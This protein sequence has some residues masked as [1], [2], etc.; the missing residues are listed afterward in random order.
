MDHPVIEKFSEIIPDGFILGQYDTKVKNKWYQV[1]NP[2]WPYVIH[3]EFVFS[4]FTTSLE[5]HLE[6]DKVK[7]IYNLLIFFQSNL[8]EDNDLLK[9]KPFTIDPTWQKGRGR[10]CLAVSNQEKPEVIASLMKAFIESTVDDI[11]YELDKLSLLKKETNNELFS[12]RDYWILNLSSESKSLEFIEENKVR[13]CITDE[14]CSIK[15]GHNVILWGLSPEGCYGLGS[16]YTDI[17]P[18]N[19]KTTKNV[20]IQLDYNFFSNP[21]LKGDIS[22]NNIFNNIIN[23]NKNYFKATDNQCQVIMAFLKNL[24]YI[25]P[26]KDILKSFNYKQTNFILN[27]ILYGP[28]GTGKTYNTIDL[29]A[30]IIGFDTNNHQENQKIFKQLLG[31]QIEFITFHQNY[32]YEDFIQGLKPNTENNGNGNLSFELKDGIFKRIA[33]RALDNYKASIINRNQVKAF[34][35]FKKVF[36]ELVKPL[37]EDGEPI[38]IPMKKVSFKIT[39]ISSKSIS[40]EKRSG[41]TGHTLSINTL[42]QMYEKGSN[43]IIMGGLQPYYNPL[44]DALKNKAESIPDIEVNE[45]LKNY[46]II[47]DEI[48]RANISRVFGELITLIEDDKRFGTANEMIITL[49][50]GEPFTVPPNL[51]LIGTMNT[52]DKSIA[53]LDIALRRRFDFIPM[54]P[55]YSIIPEFAN[56]LKPINQ[57]IKEKKGSADFMIGHSFFTGKELSN[58][59]EIINKKII[60]LLNEYFN[61]KSEI[62]KEVLRAGNIE[63]TENENFQLAYA[64]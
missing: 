47:I 7:P 16:V 32:S 31:N 42:Q 58:L 26:N 53:L 12:K 17:Y 57:K 5:L 52:A 43:E 55:D 64:N 41:G 1:K 33:D 61:G 40:F 37:I 27:Q 51:Y 34:P 50:S 6:D 28:P 36:D 39:G 11:D 48:N 8:S 44:L 30:S 19:K 54:Y 13:Y 29:A 46:V 9:N 24:N 2:L 60:P 10:L 59:S 22:N 23:I 49:P 35:P 56:I 18:L 38:E 4:E 14:K 3:F 25:K 21:I 20:N 45:E 15:D 62:I 63:V